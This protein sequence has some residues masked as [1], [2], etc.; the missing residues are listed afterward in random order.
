M[1]AAGGHGRFVDDAR[2]RLVRIL[3]LALALVACAWFALGIRQARDTNRAAAILNSTA[4]LSRSQVQQ[5]SSL[6]DGAEVLNPD[7]Q[8]DVLRARIH[9]HQQDYAGARAILERVVAKEPGNVSAWLWLAESSKGA[10]R[11]FLHALHR[12]DQ[13]EPPVRAAR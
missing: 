5:A 1:R 7:T 9:R 13:L 3:G 4:P 10:P 8:V 12:I 2:V 11:T 6:L